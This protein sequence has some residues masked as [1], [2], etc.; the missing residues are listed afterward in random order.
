MRVICPEEREDYLAVSFEYSCMKSFFKD[1]SFKDEL[2]ND[3]MNP[4]H[5]FVQLLINKQEAM[6]DIVLLRIYNKKIG[7]CR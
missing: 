7:N 6:L 3:F 2:W 5:L 1:D 4:K